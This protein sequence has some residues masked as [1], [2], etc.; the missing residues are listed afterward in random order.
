MNCALENSSSQQ[1]SSF[2][3][4][5]T[6]DQGTVDVATSELTVNELSDALKVAR[7]EPISCNF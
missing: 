3:T 2:Q 1:F 7:G 4:S 6:V 5:I